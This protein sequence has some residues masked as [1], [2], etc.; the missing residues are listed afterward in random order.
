MKELRHLAAQSVLAI[1]E[2]EYDRFLDTEG[3]EAADAANEILIGGLYTIAE[4]P[5]IGK[6]IGGLSDSY[7]R[8]LIGRIYFY[9]YI[10]THAGELF[11]FM[12]RSIDER[13]KPKPATVRR[14]Q[15]KERPGAVEL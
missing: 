8:T 9:Y 3:E 5:T 15:S 7:R 6:Q 14:R 4:N 13:K 12:L 2:A 11:V 1:L 10:N